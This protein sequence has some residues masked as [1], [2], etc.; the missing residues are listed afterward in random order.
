MTFNDLGANLSKG[1]FTCKLCRAFEKKL[2]PC[3]CSP[4]PM[5]SRSL[6]GV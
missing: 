2:L 1:N 6:P 4:R 3:V 5:C